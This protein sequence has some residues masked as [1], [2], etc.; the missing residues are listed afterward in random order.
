MPKRIKFHS[1]GRFAEI[2][3]VYASERRRDA[4]LLAA[5]EWLAP[6]QNNCR[7]RGYYDNWP[8][9][10]PDTIKILQQ[11]APSVFSRSRLR[12]MK[13]LRDVVM[14]PLTSISRKVNFASYYFR[15]F[16][17]TCGP[18]YAATTY[19]KSWMY[20]SFQVGIIKLLMNCCGW[21]ASRIEGA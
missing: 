19:K 8:P 5:A 21:W 6:L 15:L 11:N 2:C 18:T 20:C 16:T 14:D 17:T 10:S 9:A 4:A 12:T 7:E 3:V 1:Y 13:F